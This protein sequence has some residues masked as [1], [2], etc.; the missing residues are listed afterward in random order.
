MHINSTLTKNNDNQ[1][2][3]NL[4]YAN[5]DTPSNT[6]EKTDENNKSIFITTTNES[7][8]QIGGEENV[9]QVLNDG[10][11]EILQ[12]TKIQNKESQFPVTEP[13]HHAFNLNQ[14]SFKKPYARSPRTAGNKRRPVTKMLLSSIY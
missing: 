3:D 11:S 2:D 12:K 9:Y 1:T 7:D 10:F 5:L 13:Q 14:T 4:N 6:K 8:Q